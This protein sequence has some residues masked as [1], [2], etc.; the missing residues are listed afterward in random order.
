MGDICQLKLL[1]SVNS[2]VNTTILC[3][4]IKAAQV[5][6]EQRLEGRVQDGS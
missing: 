2:S 5:D 6:K 3:W 4:E 1:T